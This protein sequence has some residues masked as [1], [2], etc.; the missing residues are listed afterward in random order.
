MVNT[1]HK[2]CL[3]Q[4]IGTCHLNELL[5]LRILMLFY[6]QKDMY[7]EKQTKTEMHCYTDYS[8]NMIK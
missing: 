8:T 6:L 1:M 7:S 4:L 3:C 5:G 2:H